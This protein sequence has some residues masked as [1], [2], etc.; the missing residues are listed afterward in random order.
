MKAAADASHLLRG[1]TGDCSG[2]GDCALA[3]DADKAVGASFAAKR[4]LTVARPSNGRVTG[5]VGAAAVIDCGA[6]CAATLIDGAAVALRAAAADGH[7]F[8]SWGGACASEA[9]AS[10]SLAMDADRSVSASFAAGST[11]GRCD[12]GVVDGCA[13]GTLNRSVFGDTPSHHRWRC[14]GAN[15]GAHSPQCTKAKAGC[16]AG[17]PLH[18]STRE[19]ARAVYQGEGGLRGG[20]PRLE[21]GRAVL[22]RLGGCGVERRVGDGPGCGRPDP[23]LGAVPV[24]R[25]GLG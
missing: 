3:M 21:R 15:G 9:T 10:C 14:D 25:R 11:A 6:D 22:L 23:G 8:D 1:W 5:K 12:E 20:R 18:P 7:R 17:G 4:T 19:A 13:A 24:R 2:A 16:A